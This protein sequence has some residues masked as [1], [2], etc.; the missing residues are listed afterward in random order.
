[1]NRRTKLNVDLS[2]VEAQI[3][4]LSNN[5]VA[6]SNELDETQGDLETLSNFVYPE[7][8][9]I[10]TEFAGL[11]NEVLENEQ[12]IAALS[13]FVY[14][15]VAT[16]DSELEGLVTEFGTLSNYTY[17]EIPRIESVIEVVSTNLATN[18]ITIPDLNAQLTASYVQ[19]YEL[20]NLQTGNVT[21]SG[22]ITTQNLTGT[23]FPEN[24]LVNASLIPHAEIYH[25]IGTPVQRW[26]EG[27]FVSVYADNLNVNDNGTSRRVLLAGDTDHGLQVE[28]TDVL[29]APSFLSAD[30]V[31][32]A[33]RVNA[34]SG[35]GEVTALYNITTLSGKARYFFPEVAG[36][37]VTAAQRRVACFDSGNN[38]ITTITRNINYSVS[39]GRHVLAESG[40][41]VAVPNLW[42]SVWSIVCTVTTPLT[43]GGTEIHCFSERIKDLVSTNT[44]Y[45]V[46]GHP[47]GSGGTGTE[48]PAWVLPSQASVPLSGFL[49]DVTFPGAPSWLE[50]IQSDVLLSSFGGNL[51]YNRLT[52]VPAPA[53]LPTWADQIYQANVYVANFGGMFPWGRISD[54]PGIFTADWVTTLQSGVSLSGFSGN[55]DS[56]RI[57]NLQV[58]PSWVS[59]QQNQIVLSDFSGNLNYNRI[60][61]APILPPWVNQYFQSSVNLAGFGGTLD[62]S[63]VTGL[64]SSS[65]PGW[66]S[67]NQGAV[68]LSL[69][70]GNLDVSRIEN[71]PTL[72]LPTWITETIPDLSS[73][74]GNLDA[75]RVTNL[76]SGGSVAWL[77]ITDKPE[78]TSQFAYQ[79]IGPAMDP[80]EVSNFDTITLNSLTPASN[81]QVNIGQHQLRYRY[82]YSR[83]ARLTEAVHFGAGNDVILGVDASSGQLWT[84]AKRLTN[85]ANPVGFQDAAT[86]NYVDSSTIVN[87]RISWLSDVNLNG[88][89]LTNVGNGLSTN[90]CVTVGQVNAAFALKASIEGDNL[91]VPYGNSNQAMFGWIDEGPYF[92]PST[93][94]NR[95][96]RAYDSLTPDIE[97]S[98][99]LG[100]DLAPWYRGCI[101]QGHMTYIGGLNGGS[102]YFTTYSGYTPTPRWEIERNN[103]HILPIVTKECD[104]G[105]STRKVREVHAG[106]AVAETI[107]AGDLAFPTDFPSVRS[108]LIDFINRIYVLEQK[109]NYVI[110]TLSNLAQGQPASPPSSPVDILIELI[111]IVSPFD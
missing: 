70:G 84:N 44:T 76:P 14:T 68:T 75:S 104:L 52:D 97:R 79:N 64:P 6:L 38:L 101:Y 82:L 11:S 23:G 62:V 13:N 46:G 93:S 15:E 92:N 2:E 48:F 81:D 8:Q 74:P 34:R 105:S 107:E 27:H 109:M 106:K 28:W 35:I 49:Q 55:I 37:V 73:F 5:I 57:D 98:L 26:T 50:D 71:L 91:L 80:P 108:K 10:D 72:S 94:P 22:N 99:N 25:T 4:S 103:G 89:R 85:L 41:A 9:R 111:S 67:E 16:L 56:S 30:P 36:A 17:T 88:K 78:W 45:Y 100:Q 102:L 96:I 110:P 43:P 33:F 21:A 86:K 54:R 32:D 31:L 42:Q 77:D 69:F 60:E 63:R 87:S 65:L 18:Y 66:L 51:S 61:G 1:M 24:I 90:E 12:D 19:R 83:V 47:E 53:S 39:G 95:G 29:N 58:I 7:I 59:S 20:Q 3:I 40:G